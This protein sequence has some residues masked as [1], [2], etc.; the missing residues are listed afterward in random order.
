M[1]PELLE[2]LNSTKLQ[3]EN[4][5]KKHKEFVDKTKRNLDEF[6]SQIER[7]KSICKSFEGLPIAFD[8][9]VLRQFNEQEYRFPEYEK[10]NCNQLK[11]GQKVELTYKFNFMGNE[12]TLKYRNNETEYF[13]YSSQFHRFNDFLGII[14]S[15]IK[16]M[17]FDAMSNVVDYLEETKFNPEWK[18]S[19]VLNVLA[20]VNE[21][22]D[23]SGFLPLAD[24]LQ[25]AG[26]DNDVIIALVKVGNPQIIEW[27]NERVK[28]C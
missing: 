10:F 17:N 13:Y 1:R 7:I 25:D 24:A 19:T 22:K 21:G 6:Y 20:T 15:P 4:R 2:I 8:K 28:K 3:L 18:T 23:T 9:G 11:K 14:L 16:S 5:E 12:L 27:L 26:C